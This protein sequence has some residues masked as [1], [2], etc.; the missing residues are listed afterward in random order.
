MLQ[1]AAQSNRE[2]RRNKKMKA[3]RY[4]GIKDVRIEEISIPKRPS[5]H[6]LLR[7]AWCGICGTD[8][9]NYHTCKTVSRYIARF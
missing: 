7:V 6:L 2:R 4:Y 8:L 5:D 3:A 9:T 1:L